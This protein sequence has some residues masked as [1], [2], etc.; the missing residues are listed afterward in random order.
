M[1]TTT[2]IMITIIITT[3]TT[4]ITWFRGGRILHSAACARSPYWKYPYSD[5]WTRTFDVNFMIFR[6]ILK[7]WN[8]HVNI[9]KGH[10]ELLSTS[11][12]SRPQFQWKSTGKA[13]ILWTIPLTSDS[14]LENAAEHPS[15]NATENPRWLLRCRFLVCNLS[16]PRID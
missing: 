13:T 6:Q 16:R 1:Y 9:M 3:I 7:S 15:E 5:S 8:L 2:N 4:T 11:V 10:I 14:S 12:R